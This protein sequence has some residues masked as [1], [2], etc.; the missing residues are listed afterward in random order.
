MSWLGLFA[1]GGA[2]LKRRKRSLIRGD[3]SPERCEILRR[4]RKHYR[5]TAADIYDAHDEALEDGGL[6]GVISETS[7]LSAIARPYAEYAGRRLFPSMAKKA[8]ALTEAVAK[9]HGFT[10]GNKRTAVLCVG[11]L[12]ERSGYQ[13][14]DDVSDE[15]VEDIVLRVANSEISLNELIIWFQHRIVRLRSVLHASFYSASRGGHAP[16]DL[17]DVFG[18]ALEAFQMWEYGK[19]EPTVDLREQTVPISRVCG[20]LWNCSDILPGPLWSMM[21]DI[22]DD[23]PQRRTYGA[24]ARW[25]KD[26]IASAS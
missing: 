3:A 24:A 4:G 5:L 10:D 19:P 23:L 25:L 26:H 7:I 11:I 20:L 14:A 18:N 17:R 15:E 9:N 1:R 8:A 22:D 12:L 6:P 2:E 16:G 21:S 13:L